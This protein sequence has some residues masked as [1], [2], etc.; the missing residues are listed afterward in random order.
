MCMCELDEVYRSVLCAVRFRTWPVVN[1]IH[2]CNFC[3][4]HWH[5]DNEWS[6]PH[7]GDGNLDLRCR[8]IWYVQLYS[9]VAAVLSKFT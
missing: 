5:G 9:E 7:Q 4:N 1:S 8:Y 3:V 6:R 2:A